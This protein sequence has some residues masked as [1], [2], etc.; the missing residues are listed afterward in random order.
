MNAEI[1]DK[2]N[3][4]P[5][6]SRKKST[7]AGHPFAI[8][9]VAVAIVFG[10]SF[11]P[12]SKLTN[13]AIKDFNLF[14]SLSNDTTKQVA[15]NELL[16][17]E[18]LEAY[19]NISDTAAA[20]TL[21][22]TSAPPASVSKQ[23]EP[24]TASEPRNVAAEPSRVNGMVVFE[25]YTPGH[26]GLANLK[27]ALASGRARVAIIGDS[28]IEGDIYAKDI[29]S[30][31]QDVYGGRGVGY[32]PAWSPV[33]GFRGTVKHTS[34][35]WKQV[36]S[37]SSPYFPLMGEHY[38]GSDGARLTY[39]G[40]KD[41][42]LAAW[43]RSKVLFVAPAAGTISITTDAGEQ[44]FDIEPSEDVQEIT[45]NGTTSSLELVNHV[46]GLIYLGAYLDDPAGV[47]VD[48]MSVRGDSGITHRFINTSLASKMRQYVDYDL[49]IVEYGI[50]AL[51]AEQT[52]YD[53]YSKL[54]QQVIARIKEAYP[55]AD[56][57][58]MGIG[59]RGAKVDG[60]VHS[61]PTAP[62][63]VA[64]QRKAAQQSGILFWDTR[65]AMGGE[66]AVVDWNKRHLI[67]SDYIHLNSAGGKQLADLFVKS[68]NAKLSE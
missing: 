6:D 21:A 12:W 49:I 58:M 26:Q 1:E 64:A 31:L 65:E 45:I 53:S 37:S 35:G 15:S 22:D 2:N 38:V 10:L 62:A 23:P 61:M 56:I 52:N 13:G 3:R 24:A 42:K 41:D 36:K 48:C 19:S 68:L 54:M 66:D 40:T 30:Q 46:P 4:Q 8:V 51:T 33:M 60:A 32:M 5:A 18:L 63:M 39:K 16:D 50:N 17:P 57:V 59:D 34:T 25:D 55:R 14:A 47:A 7:K 43:S 44:T 29:R 27:S 11:V 67:N 20:A 9:F 28:Y